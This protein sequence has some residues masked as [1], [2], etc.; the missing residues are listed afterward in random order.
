M[1]LPVRELLRAISPFGWTSLTVA[2]ALVAAGWWLNWPELLVPGT[3]LAAAVGFGFLACLGRPSFGATVNLSRGRV[4]AGQPAYGTVRVINTGRRR[5]LPAGLELPVGGKRKSW[6]VPSLAS[7]AAFERG[8]EIDTSR[9]ALVPI[10]PASS[11]RGDPLGLVSRSV[12]WSDVSHLYVRPVVARPTSI[13]AG[14]LRDLEGQ[15]TQNRADSDL[16]FHALREYIPGD[17]RRHIAWKASSK[18]GTLMVRQF[19]D[20]RRTEIGLALATGQEGY[21]AWE[22]FELAVSVLASIGLYGLRAG[23]AVRVLAG[24]AELRA[25]RSQT[26]LDDCC[27]LAMSS[28][29]LSAPKA[30]SELVSRMPDAT[31]TIVVGGSGI[32]P[33]ALNAAFS[34]S[35]TGS[36]TL[37]VRA[38][39]GAEG[40]ARSNGDVSALTIGELDDLPRLLE[41]ALR[42]VR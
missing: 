2:A 7:G 32:D 8:F 11:V 1:P 13:G 35:R 3:A 5:S 37:T 34:R 33:A 38:S 15:A 17:D 39:W 10:G 12:K 30:A 25:N 9:R 21:G 29:G 36:R 4:T 31:L 18:L 28:A 23:F 22:E 24:A 14:L 6:T 19:E 41:V 27:S 42:H 40:K 20:T 26:L 16:S